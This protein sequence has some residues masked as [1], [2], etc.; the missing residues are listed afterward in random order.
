MSHSKAFNLEIAAPPQV[1]WTS[2]SKCIHVTH[3]TKYGQ[4]L[5]D[6]RVYWKAQNMDQPRP[7]IKGILI[8]AEQWNKEILPALI[9]DDKARNGHSPA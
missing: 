3:Y 8:D 4:E 9:A 5:I 7:T 1:F 2:R 6:L